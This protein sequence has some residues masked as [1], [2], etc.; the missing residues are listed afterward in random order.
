MQ[1]GIFPSLCGLANVPVEY[2]PPCSHPVDRTCRDVPFLTGQKGDEKSRRADR[3]AAD[4]S[5]PRRAREKNRRK[6]R[7]TGK[8]YRSFPFYVEKSIDREKISTR[9]CH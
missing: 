8:Q 2:P 6:K 3:A 9:D 7:K 1:E 4:G 5:A